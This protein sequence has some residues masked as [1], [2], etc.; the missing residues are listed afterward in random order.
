VIRANVAASLALL[1][2]ACTTAMP[3]SASS[4]AAARLAPGG[5]LRAAINFG[6]PILAVKDPATGEPRGVSVDLA[7][8][9]ARRLSVPVELVT[10]VAAGKVVDDATTDAW[11]IAFVA[12]DPK[13]AADMDYTAAYVLIEGAYVVP[14][15]SPIRENDEV[16]RVGVRVVVAKGSAYDLYLSRELKNAQRVHVATSQEVVAAMVTQGVEAGAGVRQQLEASMKVTP[17]VQLLPGRFMVIQ[18]AMAAPKGRAEG[19]RY[20][21]AFVE[22]MKASGFVAAALAKHGIDGAT[23]APPGAR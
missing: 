3:P 12:I 6:N 23:V 11:D 1:V 20:L 10:Y 8:E 16:D 15:G 9:L 5:K 4:E 14:R 17:G 2:A 22:E 13:R 7:R 19:A 18:Q 21:T